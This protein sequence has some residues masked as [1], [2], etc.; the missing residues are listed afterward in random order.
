MYSSQCSRSFVSL[1]ENFQFFSG[2]SMRSRN[3]RFCSGFET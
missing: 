3:R 1:A 2:R